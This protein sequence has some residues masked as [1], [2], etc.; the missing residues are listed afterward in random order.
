[1]N[2]IQPNFRLIP[3]LLR[4]TIGP[5][6]R[7]SRLFSHLTG[8]QSVF[9]QNVI[10][11]SPLITQTTQRRQ[12][13]LWVPDKKSGYRTQKELST[14]QH[15]FNGFKMIKQEIQ[16]WKEEMTEHFHADP[17]LV[18]RPGETDVVWSFGE[19][20]LNEYIV[21]SD[22]DHNEG[23]SH[24]SLT[25]SPA[26]Y[27]LFSGKLDSTVPV[28]GNLKKAGYCNVSSKRLMVSYL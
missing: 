18:C 16:L 8:S 22:S 4:T 2:S 26:G 20:D 12:F 10:D 6:K 21:T 5:F 7:C 27:G 24:C 15:I 14:T 23:L 3:L 13:E 28:R 25:K 19:S 1:M 9:T 17:V 11:W